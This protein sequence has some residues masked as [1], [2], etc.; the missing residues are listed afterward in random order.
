MELGKN[1]RENIQAY[2]WGLQEQKPVTTEKSVVKVMFSEEIHVSSEKKKSER[3][4]QRRILSQNIKYFHTY[5]K[6]VRNSN[7]RIRGWGRELQNFKEDWIWGEEEWLSLRF[8]TVTINKESYNQMDPNEL[9]IERVGKSLGLEWLF[10]DLL[11]PSLPCPASQLTRVE[12]L[13][14]T[15]LDLILSD[16]FHSWTLLGRCCVTLSHSSCWWSE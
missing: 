10:R 11:S 3:I 4:D 15:W 8:L 1:S 6:G 5:Y 16:L 12:T 2:T 14:L 9:R 7:D 13:L